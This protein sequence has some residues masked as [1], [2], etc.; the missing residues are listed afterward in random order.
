MTIR[1]GVIGSSAGNGHPY[2]WSAIFNGYESEAMKNCEYPTIPE[3]LS[4]QS[5]PEARIMGAEVS[6]IWTQDSTL[7]AKIARASR[8]EHVSST[9]NQ[10]E[11]RVDAVLL[12]RDDAENHLHFAKQFLLAGKPIYIDKPIALSTAALHQLYDLQQYTGQI[13]TCSALSY[14]PEF[15]LTSEDRDL[16]GDITSIVA[17]TPKSWEKYAVHIIEPVLKIIRPDSFVSE[18]KVY[19]DSIESR[20]L[21]VIWDSG[22]MANFSTLGNVK[23][24]VQIKLEGSNGSKNLVFKNSFSAFKMALQD[25]IDGISDGKC[26]SP[27]DFNAK[28]VDLIERGMG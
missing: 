15:I 9:L 28:V 24:P 18:A 2:S 26:R 14:A 17:S 27:F 11:S 16:L 19:N 1:L 10:M 7:S 22:L 8:I 3:Y 25:Y 6:T 21:S 23:S 13:F 12:A 20:S 5:W 4:E